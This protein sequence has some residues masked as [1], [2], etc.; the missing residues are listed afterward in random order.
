MKINAISA[1]IAFLMIF[2][3]G[4]GAASVQLPVDSAK[5]AIAIARQD[6]EVQKFIKDWSREFR[7]QIDATFLPDRGA[8]LVNIYPKGDIAD[9][10]LH[11]II[12]PDDGTII[13]KYHPAI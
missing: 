10:G 3:S 7:I 4:C 8:W 12:K 5:E 11:V 9:V 1:A 13:D 2:T 6:K